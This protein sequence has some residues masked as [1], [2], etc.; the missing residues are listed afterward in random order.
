MDA[1]LS[2]LFD[3]SNDFFCVLDK[4]GIVLYANIALRKVLGYSES[5]VIGRNAHEFSHPADTTRREEL[6][7][8]IDSVKRVTDYESRIRAKNGR[9]YNIKWSFV[10][11]EEDN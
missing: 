4:T 8:N 2:F 9:Y 7:K 6:L 3:Q 5:D 11:K 10:L 1:R